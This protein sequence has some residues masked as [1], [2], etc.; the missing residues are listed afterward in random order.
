MGYSPGRH[1]GTA[2]WCPEVET[3]SV[4]LA[5]CAPKAVHDQVRFRVEKDPPA[6]APGPIR[7]HV[8]TDEPCGDLL[9]GARISTV[10]SL[11]ETQPW[12]LTRVR[13]QAR[14]AFV[15]PATFGA[16]GLA[17]LVYD[18]VRQVHWLALVLATACSSR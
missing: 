3:L 16:I 1:H 8:E 10:L 18:H 9:L 13:V 11:P 4:D 12:T 5:R 7:P 6:P 14:S 2:H 17:V 15:F